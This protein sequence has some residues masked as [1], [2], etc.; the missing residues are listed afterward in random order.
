MPEEQSLSI[1]E[2]NKLRISLGL[3]PLT[4]DPPAGSSSTSAA[5]TSGP[6]A[7][8]ESGFEADERRAVQNWQQRASELEKVAARERQK[9]TSRKAKETARRFAKLEGKGL[10]DEDNGDDADGDVVEWVKKMKKRQ[11]RIAK[12]MEMEIA[13]RERAAVG[14]AYTEEDVKG[15]RVAHDREEF[16]EGEDVVLTLKDATIDEL[17]GM[18]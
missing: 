16:G 15:L 6:N 13:E 4:V 2:T 1:E 7:P 10:R 14:G 12:K 18:L 3:K 8:E 5:T 11:K 9:E 17:E